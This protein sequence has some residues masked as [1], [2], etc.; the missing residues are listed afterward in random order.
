MKH[1][2]KTTMRQ[3]VSECVLHNSYNIFSF[4]MIFAFTKKKSCWL[5]IYFKSKQC[6][7]FDKKIKR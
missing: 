6:F 3:N 7:G 5:T 1:L 4:V 2:L